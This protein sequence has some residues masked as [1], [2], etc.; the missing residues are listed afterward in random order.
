MNMWWRRAILNNYTPTLEK[1]DGYTYLLVYSERRV[2]EQSEGSEHDATEVNI[3]IVDEPFFP[4]L[5]A[6]YNYNYNIWSIRS[7]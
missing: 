7:Y 5:Y 4:F 3:Y 1:K 2:P 6:P